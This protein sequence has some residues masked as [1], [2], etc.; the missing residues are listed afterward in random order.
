MTKLVDCINSNLIIV[1]EN[2]C[3]HCPTIEL[4]KSFMEDC[5]KLNIYF[6]LDASHELNYERHG[7]DTCYRIWRQNEEDVFGL[8]VVGKFYMSFA[9]IDYYKSKNFEIT[10]WKSNCVLAMI[11]EVKEDEADTSC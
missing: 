11:E 4:A 7:K 6:G 3:V 9:N 10:E 5:Y 2:L 1:R 8:R